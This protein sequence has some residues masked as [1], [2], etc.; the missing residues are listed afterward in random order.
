MMN[1][2]IFEKELSS[3][4]S[5]LPKL[6][7]EEHI[8]FYLEMIDDRIEDGMSEQEA[9][10]QIGDIAEIAENIIQNVSLF[11]IAK[12]N[13]KPKRKL[14]TWE[15]ILIICG[16]PVWFPIIVSL[17]AV[18][19]SLY[20]V[21]WSLVIS[22]YAV[23]ASLIAASFAGIVSGI[24]YS[25]ALSNGGYLTIAF[26]GVA[27][28]GLSILV[29]YGCKYATIGTIKLSKKMVLWTKKLFLRKDKE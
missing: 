19:I 17:I 16:F 8:N 28:I 29:L 13:I 6:E 10:E 11:K 18:V 7:R 20:A 2:L 1:K 26:L 27:C 14:K 25:I 12:E 4:L 5:K 22:C 15:I 9:C 23:F 3:K 21:L 24:C